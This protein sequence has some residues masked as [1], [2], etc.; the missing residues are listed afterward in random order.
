MRFAPQACLALLACVVFASFSAAQSTSPSP[1]CAP[2]YSTGTTTYAIQINRVA[3]LGVD[4][5]TSGQT[6]PYYTYYDNLAAPDVIPGQTFPVTVAPGPNYPEYFR[7]YVDWDM[8]GDFNGANEVSVE[9]NI[10]NNQTNTINVSVPM[11]AVSGER[12]MRVIARYSATI[13]P[14][15]AFSYGECEDYRINV[16]ASP[17]ISNL[18]PPNA[19]SGLP[20]SHQLNVTGGTGPY[21]WTILDRTSNGAK[22]G[23]WVNINPGTGELFGTPPASVGNDSTTVRVRVTDSLNVTDEELVSWYVGEVPNLPLFDGFEGDAFSQDQ[24]VSKGSSTFLDL[25]TAHKQS[26]QKS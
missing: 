15:G 7:I 3:F 9:I 8:N 11:D 2:T 17:A 10:P 25:Q 22:N 4:N 24:S 13:S 16:N 23:N 14:C 12:R 1:Y 18:T 20:F 21:T 19:K 26:G 5:M 6:S